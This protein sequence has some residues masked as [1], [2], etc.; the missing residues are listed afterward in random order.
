MRFDAAEEWRDATGGRIKKEGTIMEII[1][2]DRLPERAG[3]AILNFNRQVR[4]PRRIKEKINLPLRERV[5]FFP[6]RGGEQFLLRIVGENGTIG[7]WCSRCHRPIPETGTFVYFG[8][9]DEGPA[10]SQFLVRLEPRIFGVFR[11][12]GETAFYQSLKPWLIEKL[13]E[14]YGSERTS[15]QGD[16]W[17]YALPLTWEDIL[18]RELKRG[19]RDFAVERSPVR[20]R[21]TRRLVGVFDTRHILRGWGVEEVASATLLG[22]STAWSSWETVA[23]GRIEAPDHKSLLLNGPHALAQTAYLWGSEGAD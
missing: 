8:G 12:K 4:A 22:T 21:R 5:W 10:H 3:R 15:R 11:Q 14:R 20:S 17:A 23:E 7:E 19:Y 13:E 16:I 2:A 1:K 18:R 9:T 6:L